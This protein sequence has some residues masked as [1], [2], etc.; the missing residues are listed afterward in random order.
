MSPMK[1]AGHFLALVGLPG[2]GKSSLAVAVAKLLGGAAFTEPEDWP[3]AVSERQDVGAFPGLMWFRAMRVPMLY[4][5][6]AIR[7]SGGVAVLDSYYDKLCAHWLR[8]AEMAW[9]L[10]PTDPWADLAV[11]VAERDWQL[12]PRADVA[13]S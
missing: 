8:R 13:A 9:L 11:A 5:A 3:P 10:P 2:S 4:E 12:L 6:A 1:D 7:D